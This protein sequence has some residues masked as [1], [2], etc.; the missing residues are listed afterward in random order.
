MRLLREAPADRRVLFYG[1]QTRM[2][3]EVSR[4]P[5]EAGLQVPADS[6]ALHNL[7]WSRTGRLWRGQRAYPMDA[8]M[9]G[10]RPSDLG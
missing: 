4:I 1:I 7:V 9:I 10:F 3:L 8:G 6:A 2:R 5:P